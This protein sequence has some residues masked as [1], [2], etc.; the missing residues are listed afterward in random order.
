M[1]ISKYLILVVS[2]TVNLLANDGSLN[3]SA[4]AE[5]ELRLND[6]IKSVVKQNSDLI[7]EKINVDI[8]KTYTTEAYSAFETRFYFNGGKNI[9]HTKNNTKDAITRNYTDTYREE[10][11][12]SDIG[13]EGVNRYGTNWNL[14]LKSQ[15]TDSSLIEAD[16]TKSTEFESGLYL[17]V[18]QPLLK[19]FGEEIGTTN[20]N[21]AKLKTQEAK[22]RYKKHVMELIGNTI[23]AYW[24]LYS[25]IEIYKTWSENI[26]LAQKQEKNI[27]YMVEAGNMSRVSL[28]EI[29]NSIRNS[30]VEMLSA[31][32][33]VNK[34]RANLLSLLNI[35]ILENTQELIPTDKPQID[36]IEIPL[37]EDAISKATLN[38]LDLN[39]IKEK[40]KQERL[41][42]KYSKNQL[43][44]DLELIGKVDS[45][46]LEDSFSNS[47]QRISNNEFNSLYFGFNFSMPIEGNMQASAKLERSQLNLKKLLLEEKTLNNILTNSLSTKVDN[48]ELNKN[49]MIELQESI[50]FRNQMIDIYTEELKYGKIDVEDL[51]DAYKK[52]VLAKRQ[53]LKGLMDVK[54]SQAVLDIAVGTL[55]DKYDINIKE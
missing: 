37:L 34:E 35:S 39:I 53:L 16:N 20:I 30:K 19:N 17:E 11:Y 7:F 14:S 51:T 6:V 9:L 28:F 24:R 26:L 46:T 23:A 3:N 49:K 18:K 36:K 25:A 27:K 50:N 54:L 47:M 5:N 1:K 22:E 33:I 43:E 4:I 45:T 44:P 42:Y 55:L 12:N 13:I 32:D 52:K 40:I 10:T 31:Q 21:I 2:C 38:W 15:K 41:V 48:L 8:S 29:Q